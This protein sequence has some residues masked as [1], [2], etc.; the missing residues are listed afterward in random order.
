MSDD[1]REDFL[2]QTSGSEHEC[3]LAKA[4]GVDLQ[5]LGIGVAGH[6][7]FNELNSSLALRTVSRTLRSATSTTLYEAYPDPPSRPQF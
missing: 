5:L 3:I 4:G 7:G 1:V 6:I 2:L